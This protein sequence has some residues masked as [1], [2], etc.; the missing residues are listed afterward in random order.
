M[1]I[2]VSAWAIRNPVPPVIIFMVLILLGVMSFRGLPITRFPNIDVPVI[3]VS[4]SQGGAAP[5]EL[6]AQVTKPI[7]DAISAITGIKKINSTMS[8]GDASAAVRSG[9]ICV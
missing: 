2:N 8:D 7:E 1:N 4:V 6:E 3:A 5:V 9:T